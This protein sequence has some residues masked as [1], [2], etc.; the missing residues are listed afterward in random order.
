MKLAKM[1]HLMHCEKCSL[2][3]LKEIQREKAKVTTLKETKR[4]MVH[5]KARAK[6]KVE[7]QEK[8]L[9]SKAMVKVQAPSPETATTVVRMVTKLWTVLSQGRMEDSTWWISIAMRNP[10]MQV[11]VPSCLQRQKIRW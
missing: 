8:A 3:S 1:Y 2:L 6:E 11:V 10:A 5:S 9:A 7:K 4:V